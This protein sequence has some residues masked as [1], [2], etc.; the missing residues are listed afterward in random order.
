MPTKLT[1]DKLGR[2]VLPKSVR[3]KLQLSPGTKLEL[4]SL[5][6]GITLPPLRGTEQLRKKR[7]FWVFRSGEPLSAATVQETIDQ[8]HRER[9]DLN[10]G[11]C[12]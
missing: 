1:I 10:L 6:D 5:D 8:V 3:E 2:I 11:K 9:N 4:E 12:Q 7:G